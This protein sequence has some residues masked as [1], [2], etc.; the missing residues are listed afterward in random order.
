M[1]KIF[2]TIL[3]I[4]IV[5]FGNCFLLI[6]FAQA[7]NI[8]VEIWDKETSSF[9]PLAGNPVFDGTNFLP[10]DTITE[11][12]KVTNYTPESQTVGL[13]VKNFDKG[14]IDSYCL[15]DKLYLTVVE[16]NPEADTFFPD[17]SDF[18]K[19]LWQ[20]EELESNGLKYKFLE[21]ER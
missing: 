11:R 10:E 2:K 17:Y 5:I 4:S 9:K 19:V 13:K 12:I 6:N 20:S 1:N 16:G 15:S 21:L 7:K 8:L 3:I 14:C 18:E